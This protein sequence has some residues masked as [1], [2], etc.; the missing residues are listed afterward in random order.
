MAGVLLSP[1]SVRK[2]LMTS[3]WQPECELMRSPFGARARLLGVEQS[4]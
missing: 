1:Q 2:V 3:K 4:V